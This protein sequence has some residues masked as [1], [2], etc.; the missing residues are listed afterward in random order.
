MS[1]TRTGVFTSRILSVQH[2]DAGRI[3]VN[4]SSMSRP[5]CLHI[6]DAGMI[7]TDGPNEIEGDKEVDWGGRVSYFSLR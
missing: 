5:W 3:K 1:S 7:S 6:S 2:A 4:P